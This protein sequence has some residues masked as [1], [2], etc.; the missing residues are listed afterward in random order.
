MTYGTPVP[1]TPVIDG[2][3]PCAAIEVAVFN[4]LGKARHYAVVVPA[5]LDPIAMGQ[6][7][8]DGYTTQVD[9]GEFVEV[10]VILF[11][12][13]DIGDPAVYREWHQE[14]YHTRLA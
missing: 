3:C 12:G 2:P 7:I 14:Y 5:M 1:R 13:H 6:E 4:H 9:S 10:L 11:G 8:L